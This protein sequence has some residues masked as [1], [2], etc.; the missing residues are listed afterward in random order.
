MNNSSDRKKNWQVPDVWVL[1]WLHIVVTNG[2]KSA[3]VQQRDEHQHQHG[4]LKKCGPLV[5]SLKTGVRFPTV[6]H[7]LVWMES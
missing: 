7:E 3:V 1:R 5:V 6:R 2:N 4:K